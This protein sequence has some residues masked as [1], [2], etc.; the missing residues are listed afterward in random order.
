VNYLL[1]PWR[2]A[3]QSCCPGPPSAPARRSYQQR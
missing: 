1:F 2:Q 3:N